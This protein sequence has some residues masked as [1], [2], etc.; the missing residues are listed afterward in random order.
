MH[1]FKKKKK[2]E[3]IT[4]QSVKKKKQ[5]KC[6]K[7][8][9]QEVDSIRR[10]KFTKLHITYNKA[11]KTFTVF[12]YHVDALTG[13]RRCFFLVNS[14]EVEGNSRGVSASFEFISKDDI[15]TFLVGVYSSSS[16]HSSDK[17]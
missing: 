5:K 11:S 3:I 13:L 6:N 7:L 10:K 14:P 1:I 9:G 16:I 8:S 2:N 15:G 12:L 17:L 4:I